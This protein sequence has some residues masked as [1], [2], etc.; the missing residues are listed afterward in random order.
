MLFLASIPIYVLTSDLCCSP[1][2][3]GLFVLCDNGGH[4]T[5]EGISTYDSS[6]PHF[7]Y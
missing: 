4:G 7:N 1:S 2:H 3:Q 6:V 5:Q